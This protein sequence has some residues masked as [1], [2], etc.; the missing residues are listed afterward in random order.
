MGSTDCTMLLPTKNRTSFL[1]MALAYYSLIEFDLP[2]VIADSSDLRSLSLNSDVIKRYSETISLT[3][4]VFPPEISWFNKVGEAS[5]QLTTKFLVM[6]ADDDFWNKETLEKCIVFIK[7]NHDYCT[8]GGM[9]A[10]VRVNDLINKNKS[11]QIKIIRAATSTSG[12]PVDRGLL[13]ASKRKQRMYCV[14]RLDIFRKAIK[15][16]REIERETVDIFC[17]YY[18]YL[19]LMLMGKFHCVNSVGYIQM[20]HDGAH[21]NVLST[22]NNGNSFE[23]VVYDGQKQQ[24]SGNIQRFLIDCGVEPMHAGRATSQMLQLLFEN[25]EHRQQQNTTASTQGDR[26]SCKVVL[27]SLLGKL[28]SIYDYFVGNVAIAGPDYRVNRALGLRNSHFRR[29]L[30]LISEI[31]NRPH[32]PHK[33]LGKKDDPENNWSTNDI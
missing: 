12:D 29:T 2:I 32:V 10:K 28:I 19:Y 8:V 14:H 9:L 22:M 15:S 11:P 24:A 20:I 16:T 5:R 7:K 3:H 23:G 26:I 17:E 13:Y 30:A 6:A 25:N 18:F 1:A 31:Y 4:L 33:G 27:V 21:S